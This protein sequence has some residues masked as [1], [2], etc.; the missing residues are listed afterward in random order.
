M[1][2]F[3]CLPDEE[4]GDFSLELR[5]AIRTARW[6]RDVVLQRSKTAKSAR[7]VLPMPPTK[8]RQDAAQLARFARGFFAYSLRSNSGGAAPMTP[9]ITGQGHWRG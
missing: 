5:L 8:A 2:D 4:E 9:S 1:R 3:R 7:R 6:H